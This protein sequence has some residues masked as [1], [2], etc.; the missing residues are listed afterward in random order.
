MLHI[1][2]SNLPPYHIHPLGDQALVIDFGNIISES[3]NKAVVSL[4]RQFKQHPL[5]EIEEVI[6]AYSSLA[7]FYDVPFILSESENSKSAFEQMSE[8]I[9]DYLGNVESSVSDNGRVFDIPVCY[10]EEWAT[11]LKWMAEEKDITIKKIIE[12]HT[13]ITYRVYMLGF[14]PGF[15]YMGE[16]D[17][18]LATPRKSKP[19]QVKWGSVGIAGRQTGIYPFDSPGGWQIIGRC[20]KKIFNHDKEDPVF[21]QPGDSV[22]FYSITRDEFE[23]YQGGHS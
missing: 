3:I 21:F 12:L 11:D 9:R 13:S 20:P 14:L 23:N 10:D 7:V 19:M 4:F 6:P 8:L 5:K 17:E 16:V 15:A 2:V 1:Q 22:K 18:I